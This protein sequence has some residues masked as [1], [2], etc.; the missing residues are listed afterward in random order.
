M[1]WLLVFMSGV[2]AY[3]LTL[4]VC[5]EIER[6][7]NP[8]IVSIFIRNR[9]EHVYRNIRKIEANSASTVLVWGASDVE[10][11]IDPNDFE[12][13]L[14][15]EGLDLTV[16]NLGLR[17]M[18]L[19]VLND[20][21]DG[22]QERLSSG[23]KKFAFSVFKVPLSRMTY[24]YSETLK[25]ENFGTI[26][27]RTYGFGRLLGDSKLGVAE[28]FSLLTEKTIWRLASPDS[29][30]TWV[31]L[32]PTYIQFGLYDEA[33]QRATFF[34]IWKW[35][36]FLERPEWRIERKGLYGFN[37]PKASLRFN[38]M[39][40]AKQNPLV[41]RK[42]LAHFSECCD[43]FD[44]KFD[45][46]RVADLLMSVEKLKAIS[47]RVILVITPDSEVARE[48]RTPEALMRLQELQAMLRREGITV[49]DFNREEEVS[50]TSDLYVDFLHLSDRGWQ[51]V[52]PKI[53]SV[54]KEFY[55]GR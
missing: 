31:Q 54:M 17:S 20:F 39:V 16:Y 37:R 43:Y 13:A 35:P 40:K 51:K 28:K 6:D 12:R 7:F 11:F 1:R 47:E 55:A 48:Q 41:I 38:E 5:R 45:P 49:V 50:F 9:I 36:K 21:I 29:F 22:F 26:S 46:D 4:A 18:P 44:L 34:S 30:Q 32:L 27:A 52:Y 19:N 53:V 2:A 42:G 3:V 33:R 25:R 24:T 10:G 14:G 23:A 8:Q 15:Q